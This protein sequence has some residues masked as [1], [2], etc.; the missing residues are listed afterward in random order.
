MVEDPGAGEEDRSKFK[1]MVLG[2]VSLF[3]RGLTPLSLL[4]LLLLLRL[5]VLV[6]VPVVCNVVLDLCLLLSGSVLL[7]LLL[8]LFRV[9]KDMVLGSLSLVERGLTPLSFPLLRFPP[10]CCRWVRI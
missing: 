9:R 3:E 8:R 2:S 4:L 6:G 5:A 7:L 1:D 10:P